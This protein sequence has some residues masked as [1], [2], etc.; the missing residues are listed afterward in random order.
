MIGESHDNDASGDR[1][2]IANY[3]GTGKDGMTKTREQNHVWG[4]GQ[5]WVG[6]QTFAAGEI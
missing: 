2:A 3:R 4:D 6:L 5:L 1:R